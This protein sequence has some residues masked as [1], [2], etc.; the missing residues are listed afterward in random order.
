MAHHPIASWLGVIA[1]ALLMGVATFGVINAF[2]MRFKQVK[3]AKRPEIRWD[4]IPQ[5]I[6]NV[7]VYVLGQKRLPRNGYTYSGVLHMFIFG[8]FVVLSVD[9]T[10]FVLDGTFRMFDVIL[11]NQ[12]GGPFHLPGS[13]GP[14][15]GLADTFR[16]LCI[17]GLGMA[18]VNRT[19]IK[20]A[21]L[22]S[23][24]MPSTPWPSSSA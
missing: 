14:Y 20:P 23:P 24:A 15:Q 16:F 5:R 10:N 12:P 19:I 17:V 11:G 8:A 21:R 7:M 13:D 18:L 6:K 9:T 22:P 1:F 4:E 2:V 3:L